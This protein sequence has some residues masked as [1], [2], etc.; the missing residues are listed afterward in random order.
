MLATVET[1]T[2]G[3]RRT[4]GPNGCPTVEGSDLERLGGF[5]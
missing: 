2:V 4:K 5:D 1:A 3:H